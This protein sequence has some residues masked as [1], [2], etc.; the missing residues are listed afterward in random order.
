MRKQVTV[1]ILTVMLMSIVTANAFAAQKS[2]TIGYIGSMMADSNSLCY[3]GLKEYAD[4]QG[5]T[6]I[7]TDLAGESAKVSEAMLKYVAR[8]VDAIAVCCSEKTL[9]DMGVEAAE[10]AGIPVFLADT[11]NMRSTV[12]NVTT[13][14]WAM[15]AFLGSQIVDRIRAM[16]KGPGPFNVCILGLPDLYVHRQRQEMMEALFNSPENPEFKVLAT[17]AIVG[18]KFIEDA[19]DKTKAWLARYGKDIDCIV[20][21]WDGISWGISR[22]ISDAGYT[23][24]DIFTMSI[25]GSEHTYDLI[26][27]GEP[28]VGVIAQDFWGWGITMGETIKA[29]VVEGQDPKNVVPPSRT[30]Y[31]PYYWVDASNV[32]PKGEERSIFGR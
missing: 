20:G 19:Y 12:V 29:V 25:D 21:T 4:E 3:A 13:N 15:G 7:L 27:R 1:L 16:K 32:P 18:A 30:I 26:R 8:G 11:E 14:C 2:I 23:K 17:D 28:F 31:L 9:I 6:V 5:W 22:A 24:D 10:K